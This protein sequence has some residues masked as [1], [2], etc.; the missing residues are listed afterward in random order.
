MNDIKLLDCTLRD[1][2]YINQ[3]KFGKENICGILQRL[4]QSDIDLIECGFLTEL[5]KNENYTLFSDADELNQYIPS[6]NP[7]TMYVAMIAIGEK[8]IHPDKICDAKDTIL[9]GIR[10]TFHL[11][12]AK[13]AFEWAE[14]LKKKGY[15]VFIQPVGSACYTDETILDLLKKVNTLA[16]YAFYIVDTLGAMSIKDM[17]HMLHLI[18]KNLNPN[19]AL[20]YH[21][22]NNLQLSFANAQNM[23]EFGF[24]R[25]ILI[26]CSVYGMGRGAGNLCTELM[27]DYLKKS[28]DAQ[29]DVIPI[30]EIVDNYLMTIYLKH[31]W[32]YSVAYFL[33]STFSCHPNYVSYLLTKQNMQVHTIRSLLQQIPQ[34]CRLEYHPEIIENIYR[35]YQMN[36][37]DDSKEVTRL[38]KLLKGKSILML[39]PGKSI[40]S[41]HKQIDTYRKKHHPFVI[42][43]NFIPNVPVDLY[44]IANQKRYERIRDSLPLEQT[45]FTSN[46]KDLPQD[47]HVISYSELLNSSRTIFDSSGLMLLKLLIRA[48]VKQVSIAGM[49]GFR[50]HPQEN[51]FE[52]Q[53]I[54][55]LDKENVKQ[56]NHEM[57]EQIALFRK[58]IGI[59]FIT[60][61]K[62][63]ET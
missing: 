37:I 29:Y 15:Q 62:Y 24:K 59:D 52:N 31:P 25:T 53:F 21:S 43:T 9:D 51:Y 50:I 45:I 41:K 30:L 44:F 6:P 63:H 3:W 22:H 4:S 57:K 12:Q 16:P 19:I 38:R 13:K 8:E 36:S 32:G 49:D 10:L 14:L 28:R 55:Q 2:G 47:A 46:I 54:H 56:L 23:A 7:N 5:C 40:K 20:G 1:G 35:M 48:K 26:D 61:S 33:A 42:A 39:A 18:D 11:D 17:M 34:K 60:P 58:E 27:M